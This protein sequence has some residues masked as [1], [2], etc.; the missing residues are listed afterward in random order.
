MP[1]LTPPTPS[2]RP[3]PAEVGITRV[4]VVREGNDRAAKHVRNNEEPSRF[5]VRTG[6]WTATGF[7][8]VAFIWLTG[9]LGETL[10]FAASLGVPDLVTSTD[11]GL[12]TGVG[13]LVG[14]PRR[15][16]EMTMVDPFRLVAACGLIAIPAAGL[17][18]ARPRVPGG[19][20]PSK[21]AYGFSVMGIIV[22]TLVFAVLI[23]WTAWP[24]R[25]AILGVAPNDRVA[26]G[27]WLADVRAIAGFDALAL[28]ASLLWLVLL[29]RV[30]LPRPLIALASIAG[31]LAAFANWNGFAVSNGIAHGYT[32][33]RPVILALTMPTPEKASTEEAPGPFGPDHSL[34]IGSLQGRATVM[35]SSL[36]PT[37]MALSVPEFAAADRASVELWM[38][39]PPSE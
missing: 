2:K 39:P 16:F 24:G 1:N 33:A 29:F 20:A 38:K 32:A 25:T 35:T 6:F 22:A 31:F 4:V 23:T 28:L 13:M 18:V 37:V 19:P 17:A 26:F 8:A 7:G 5:G 27:T 30:P 11:H 10:G 9:H 15:I 3:T 34:L 36:R 12:A 14:V 21:L